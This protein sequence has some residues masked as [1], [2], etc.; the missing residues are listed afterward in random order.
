MS[1]LINKAKEILNNND[2]GTHTIP[3]STL[4]PHMWA[5][6][7]AFAAIGWSTFN[8]DRATTELETLLDASWDDGLYLLLRIR[9]IE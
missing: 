4:Y 9:Q 1:T 3:S 5:W 7:S 8:I 6:D 2:H